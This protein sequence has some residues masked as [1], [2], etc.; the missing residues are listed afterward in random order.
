MRSITKKSPKKT[1]HPLSIAMKNI[2]NRLI[3]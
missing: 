1:S 2:D 3:L